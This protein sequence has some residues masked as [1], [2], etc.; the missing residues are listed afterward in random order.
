M[1]KLII[2]TATSNL[3]LALVE[4]EGIFESINR[5]NIEHSKNIMPKIDQLLK[6][7]N[8]DIQE[9]DGII[10]G[11]GPGSYTGIR[12]GVSV[13]KMLAWTLGCPLYEVSSLFV[14]GSNMKECASVIDAR[15]GNVFAGAYKNGNIIIK[16]GLYAKEDFLKEA[17]QLEIVFEE[18]FNPN[19][20]RII[21]EAKEVNP[22]ACIPNYLR[23]TEAERNLKEKEACFEK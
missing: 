17:K 22:H 18:N 16:E 4:D 3:Y 14:M 7:N 1:K 20:K 6:D 11:V 5:G 10:V 9:I 13:A 23:E 2:D 12:I 21:E 8:V 15:R 19:P